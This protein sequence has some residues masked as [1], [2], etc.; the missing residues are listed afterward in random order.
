MPRVAWW[1]F[2]LLCALPIV[3]GMRN[4]EE[5]GKEEWAACQRE[6]ANEMGAEREGFEVGWV[7]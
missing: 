2:A 6:F 1:S 4:G 5:E 7:S 3:D